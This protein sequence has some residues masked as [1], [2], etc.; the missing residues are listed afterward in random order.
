MCMSADGYVTTP[1]GLP[2][3]LADSNFDRAAYVVASRAVAGDGPAA[4]RA[5]GRVIR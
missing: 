5:G 3:Q 4:P 2:V 1:D